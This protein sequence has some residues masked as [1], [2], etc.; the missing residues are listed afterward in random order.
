M[1]KLKWARW[2]VNWI[3][4]SVVIFAFI[5]FFVYFDIIP[6]LW[7]GYRR[8]FTIPNIIFLSVVSG[9]VFSAIITFWTREKK[10]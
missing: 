6:N 9:L 4:Y 7:E 5:Y 1:T 2:I 3:I 10:K 8:M